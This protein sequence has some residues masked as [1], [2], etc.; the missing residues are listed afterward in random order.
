MESKQDSLEELTTYRQR[1]TLA[2]QAAKVC[3]F[4]VD[5]PNQRYTYFEN[6]EVIYGKSG[7][8]IL[9]D[10]E[11]FCSMSP[12][13]YQR[14]VSDY[15]S[16]PEDYAVID[17]AFRDIFAGRPASYVARMR[18][19][20]AQFAWCKISVTPIVENGVTT[21]MVGV[22]SNLDNMIRESEE[23]R[24]KSEQDPLTGLSNRLGL[25]RQV[26]AALKSGIP[27]HLLLVADLDGLKAL[28]REHG[29]LGGDRAL[30]DFAQ[31]LVSRFPDAEAIARWGGDEFVILLP[32]Q[33]DQA[34][35]ER[36]LAPFFAGVGTRFPVTGSFGGTALPP[37]LNE[38]QR[39]FARADRALYDAKRSKP[40]FRMCSPE[41]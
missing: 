30:L 3:I 23:H 28:N 39:A 17:Q 31:A 1:L 4:E 36:R 40:A 6:A 21:R 10:L 7:K 34:A 16:H 19:G 14:G 26:E 33:Q 5:I 22:V 37:D 27:S 29:H 8:E 18:A 11:P 15:F 38:V 12:A 13:D 41:E 2:L 35:L 32:W 20:N 9:R 25:K 24:A